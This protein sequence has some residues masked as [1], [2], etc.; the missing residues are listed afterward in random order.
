MAQDVQSFSRIHIEIANR[1]K[2]FAIF[3]FAVGEYISQK[4]F[5]EELSR[6]QSDLVKDGKTRLHSGQEADLNTTGGALAIQ[7]YME[8]VETARQVMSGLSKL[9]LS[10]EKQVWKLQ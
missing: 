8:T 3:D 1:Q 5:F 7:I 9:G 4:T 10:I 2:V 6:I